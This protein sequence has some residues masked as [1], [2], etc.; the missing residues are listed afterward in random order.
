MDI[1]GWRAWAGGRIASG[2]VLLAVL[3]LCGCQRQSPTAPL[4]LNDF[5]GEAD[6]EQIAWHC[7]TTFSLS[8]QYRSHGQSGL[9]MTLYPDLY[10]GLHLLLTPPMRQWRGYRYLALD[11]INPGSTPLALHYRIDDYQ[12]PEYED[13]INGSFPLQPG[14]N[15]L[16][17]DLEQLKTSGSKRPLNLDRIW[18]LMFFQVSPA[19]P[20]VL[21][22]DYVRLE[23]D[24]LAK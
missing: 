18:A 3:L 19:Q 16:R 6:L 2:C 9:L 10:P 15:R 24:S 1:R 4:I 8:G 23:T 12:N 17:L 22:V 20:L 11:V 13:R 14:E 21:G 7:R 5:E